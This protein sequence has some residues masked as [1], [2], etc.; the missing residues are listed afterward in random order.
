MKKGFSLIEL[1]LAILIASF[2]SISLF[3]LLST[4]RKA[5]NRITNVIELD[6][7]FIAFYSQLEKD[8]LGMFAP[9]SSIA[10]YAAQEPPKKEASKQ[11]QPQQQPKQSNPEEKNKHLSPLIAYLCLKEKMIH[12][13]CPL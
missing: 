9:R 13:C 12:L 1:V 2:V 11:G 5:V 3:Q 7:P 4:T 10:H 8:M 6:V